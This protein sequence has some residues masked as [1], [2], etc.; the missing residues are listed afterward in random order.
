MTM[1]RKSFFLS[2]IGSA[3]TCAAVRL[4]MSDPDVPRR[5]DGRKGFCDVPVIIYQN[6]Q[7][8]DMVVAYDLDRDWALVYQKDPNGHVMVIGDELADEERHGGIVVRWDRN[9]LARR[10]V[11]RPA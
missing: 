11:R 10:G 6:G 4:G 1:N 3:V 7:K 2:L 9:E 8:L 5:L